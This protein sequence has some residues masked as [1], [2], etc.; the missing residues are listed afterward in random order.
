[1]MPIAMKI[2][3]GPMTTD[4]IVMQ[5]DVATDVSVGSFRAGASIGAITTEQSPASVAGNVISREHWL[6]WSFDDD[7]WLVRAGRINV[8][9]G[10]RTLDHTL[11]VRASTRTDLNETQEDG[12]A[13]AYTGKLVRGEVMAIAGN[14]SIPSAEREYGYSGYLELMPSTWWTVGVSSLVTNASQDLVTLQPTTRQ[15]HGLFARVAP[16]GPLALTAEADFIINPSGQTDA[17]ALATMV[18]ADLEVLRGVHLMATGETQDVAGR[19]GL[20]VGGWMGV[21]WFFASHT[22][23]RFDF[24]QRSEAFGNQRVA[25]QAFML[26]AHVYF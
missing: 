24:M 5:A 16:W 13:L 25:E 20:S 12:V 11:W 3:D 18:Q 23:V 10:A 17:R 1:V 14:F 2:G 8:P 26:Q 15:A 22:D 19:G 9:F 6:G 4:L 7:A 21:G